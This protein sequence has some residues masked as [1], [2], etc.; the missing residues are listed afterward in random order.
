MPVLRESEKVV[1]KKQVQDRIAMTPE[2]FASEAR[3]LMSFINQS[4]G[5]KPNQ[6]IT[7]RLLRGIA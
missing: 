7:E 5:E 4:V 2:M 3:M 1:N 6:E